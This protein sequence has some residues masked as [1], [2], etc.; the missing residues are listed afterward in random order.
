MGKLFCFTINA[1]YFMNSTQGT[2]AILVEYNKDALKKP[3]VPS[4]GM[5]VLFRHL[6]LKPYNAACN[7]PSSQQTQ[8]PTK[9]VPPSGTWDV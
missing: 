4:R 7:F 8:M 9:S 3:S 6:S 2:L 1:K 5:K